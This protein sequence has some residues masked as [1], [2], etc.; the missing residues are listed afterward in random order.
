MSRFEPRYGRNYMKPINVAGGI[1]FAP[2]PL[3][4]FTDNIALFKDIS[5]MNV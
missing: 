5:G 1:A 3:V 2:I 4:P